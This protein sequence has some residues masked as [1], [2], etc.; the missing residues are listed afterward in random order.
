MSDITYSIGTIPPP[1]SDDVPTGATRFEILG[2]IGQGGMGRVSEA[3]DRQFRRVV[4]IK[5]VRPEADPGL[6]RRFVQEALVTGQLDHPAVPAV[7]ERGVR[8]DGTPWY[9]MR[10]IQGSTLGA[11]LAEAQTGAERLELLPA[12]VQVALAIAH[13]HERGVVHRDLKPDNILIGSRGQAI[14]LDWGL[15]KVRGVAV[16]TNGDDDGAPTSHTRHGAVLGT[17]GYM[18]PEQAQ[19]RPVDVDERTDV[20]ALGAL[21]YHLLAGRPPYMGDRASALLAAAC[22]GQRPLLATVAPDAPLALRA[23]AERAMSVEPSRRHATAGAFADDLQGVLVD[24]LANPVTP[25][26]RI[27][28]G[29]A[30]ALVAALV[31]V[32][33]FAGVFL[34]PSV[35]EM[36]PLSWFVLVFAAA[37]VVIAAVEHQSGGRLGLRP[38]MLALAGVTLLYGLGATT[39]GLARVAQT[40]R[41]GEF[42]A[43]VLP[44]V[45]AAGV[46]EALGGVTLAVFLAAVEVLGWGLLGRRP[47]DA[48]GRAPGALR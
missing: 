45:V 46:Q 37:W 4:A 43:D 35:H 26:A 39:L 27:A 40:V 28:A 32:M 3:W 5:E 13:A 34:L 31:M 8:A 30:S 36:G 15:A 18:A 42:P 21:L 22:A 9:A 11:R 24:A 16:D 1:D 48:K 6:H 7:Y 38:L 25:R 19:G 2:P 14:V 33:P 23:V 41:F 47:P 17:L 12:L 20:F 44:G 29:A 10:R